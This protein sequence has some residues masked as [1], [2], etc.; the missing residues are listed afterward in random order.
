[1]PIDEA[2]ASPAP[3]ASYLG[4]YLGGDVAIAVA[5]FAAIS[6]FGT[7]NGWVLVQAEM[8]WA[9]A[10]GGVF[11]AWF[12]QEGRHGTPVRSHLVSSGLLS[13]ITLL[14]YQKGMTDLFGFIASVSLAAGLVAYL[15][16]ALAALK[17]ARG[18]ALTVLAALVAVAF[19]FWAEYGLGTEAMLY[20]ALLIGAG[21]PV[22]LSVRTAAAS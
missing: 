21:L 11:P 13:G 2:A 14:N 19:F 7:L 10:K 5:L 16:A 3:I 1:M 18:Q 6:A 4:R 15:M 22:Y 8:P 20:A 17:L 9:M 12:A